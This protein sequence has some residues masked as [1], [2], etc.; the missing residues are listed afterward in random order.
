MKS[1]FAHI[2]TKPRAYSG[3]LAFFRKKG[4]HKKCPPLALFLKMQW[5]FLVLLILIFTQTQFFF[6]CKYI[7]LYNNNA[8]GS[9]P[10][11]KQMKV[12]VF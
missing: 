5:D 12:Q 10:T 11:G 2:N 7:R 4:C 3:M 6:L 1:S 9:A 8:L